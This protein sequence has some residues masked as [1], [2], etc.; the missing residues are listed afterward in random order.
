M[1]DLRIPIG[2]F[3]SIIGL[4]LIVVGLTSSARAPLT[5]M[6]INLYAGLCMLVFGGTM[7]WLSRRAT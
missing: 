2:L 7:L 6:N 5:D 4:I 3:F 1:N